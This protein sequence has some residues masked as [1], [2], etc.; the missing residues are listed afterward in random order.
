LDV[1]SPESG[2]IAI[3]VWKSP[4][5]FVDPASLGGMN[6]TPI[7]GDAESI[8]AQLAVQNSESTLQY[9]YDFSLT[10]LY[11]FVTLVSLLLWGAGSQSRIVSMA[12]DLHR[13][14]RPPANA[15]GVS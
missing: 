3:R 10:I 14:T 12:C 6:V 15:G 13:N 9:L 8:A 5:L 4:L 11:G 2:T 1:P 7:S